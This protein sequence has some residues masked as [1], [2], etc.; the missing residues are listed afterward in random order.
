MSNNFLDISFPHDPLCK[1]CKSPD[2]I[3]ILKSGRWGLY[4]KNCGCFIKWAT[5]EQKAVITARLAF[6]EKQKEVAGL[7]W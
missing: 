6:I 4:C 5:Q 3:A 2:E 7:K 1:K